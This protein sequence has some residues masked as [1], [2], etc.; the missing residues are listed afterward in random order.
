MIQGRHI[1]HEPAIIDCSAARICLKDENHECIRQVIMLNGDWHLPADATDDEERAFVIQVCAAR[2]GKL[3]L[4]IEHANESAEEMQKGANLVLDCSTRSRRRIKELAMECVYRTLHDSGLTKT[5]L[6]VL[7]PLD[8]A[9]SLGGASASTTGPMPP[10]K[11]GAA[12]LTSAAS[13]GTAAKAASSAA[14]AGAAPG[15]VAAKAAPAAAAARSER[16]GARLEPYLGGWTKP[17]GWVPPY[18]NA[19]A[20]FAQQAGRFSPSCEPYINVAARNN[21]FYQDCVV[22]VVDR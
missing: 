20:S 5:L 6:S 3:M 9:E 19:G 2:G 15:V 7:P 12:V 16:R 21:M 10:V 18:S 4:Y 8:P 22:E 13:V 1:Y 14:A 17:S 11:T